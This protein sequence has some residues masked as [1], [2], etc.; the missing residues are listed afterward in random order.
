[1]QS[2]SAEVHDDLIAHFQNQ[3][4]IFPPFIWG[5]SSEPQDKINTPIQP[6]LD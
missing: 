3:E 1:M 5:W 2:R 6:S 4:V